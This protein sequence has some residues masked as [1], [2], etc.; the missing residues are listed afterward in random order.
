MGIALPVVPPAQ[1]APGGRPKVRLG[2][3]KLASCDGCQLTLLDLEDDLLAI[4]DRFEILEF[5][6]AS[7][8]R[9]P[10]GPFDVVLVE[11]SV[12][13]PEQ[14]DEIREIRARTRLLVTIG[15]C[16][17]S[18]GIQAMRNWA[19][20]P[21]FRASV[22]PTPA[23][24][25]SLATATPV[26]D[27]V[28]VDVE[29]RGCPIDPHGL[30]ELLG[31]LVAGRRPQLPDEAV[32]LECKRQGRVCVLVAKGTAC[33]GPVTHAG[34]GALCPTYARGC[35]ACFG[36][37]ESANAASLA[38]WIGGGGRA[39]AGSGRT[40]DGRE[41]PGP[42]VARLYA[43]FTGYAQPFRGIVTDLGGPPSGMTHDPD[44]DD[45]DAKGGAA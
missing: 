38:R 9:S 20:E 8:R 12:S 3:F 13:T 6:E 14:V 23:Y 30:L 35:Y 24:I 43:G 22:Y 34:C 17:I 29:L 21:E 1:P 40:K 39:P 44:A 37:K 36:P 42:E 25:E 5:A 32:C 27:H 26:A 7:S 31:A 16:A 33:L 2:V 10:E 19:D 18:G 41:R 28:K 11:G 15:A 4:G 45:A